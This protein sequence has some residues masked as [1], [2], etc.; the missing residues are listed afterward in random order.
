[1]PDLPAYF[2]VLL[3][4]LELSDRGSRTTDVLRTVSSTTGDAVPDGTL[5]KNGLDHASIKVHQDYDLQ[6]RSKKLGVSPD[7]PKK[8]VPS[9]DDSAKDLEANLK[10]GERG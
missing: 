4:K 1:V 7:G 3:W 10:S 8:A 5:N 6:D 9:A 2:A